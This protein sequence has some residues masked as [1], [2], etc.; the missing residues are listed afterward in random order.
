MSR[1]LCAALKSSKVDLQVAC[2]TAATQEAPAGGGTCAL[3]KPDQ[4]HLH[5]PQQ[6][7]TL[8]R[9]KST[10]LELP[11]WD[12]LHT[13]SSTKS[14]VVEIKIEISHFP[15]DTISRHERRHSPLISHFDSYALSKRG[16]GNLY[17][18]NLHSIIGLKLSQIIRL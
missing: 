14:I 12:H 13:A 4:N 1:W 9:I 10:K 7:T 15:P 11:D 6:A 17:T 5:L 18:T 8:I 16:I 2:F 3:I